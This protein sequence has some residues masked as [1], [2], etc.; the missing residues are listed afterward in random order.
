MRNKYFK[1]RKFLS[2]IALLISILSTPFYVA[3]NEDYLDYK[4]VSEEISR[5]MKLAPDE[6]C[7]KPGVSVFE[8]YRNGIHWNYFSDLMERIRTSTSGPKDERIAMYVACDRTTDFFFHRGRVYE[9]N[10]VICESFHKRVREYLENN[11]IDGSS[12]PASMYASQL[13]S[14]WDKRTAKVS[15]KSESFSIFSWIFGWV[16]SKYS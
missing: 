3:A 16:Q 6:R 13:L 5:C 9:Y 11:T 2:L 14:Y 15:T 12:F 7:T 10:S 8:E 1:M 4:I